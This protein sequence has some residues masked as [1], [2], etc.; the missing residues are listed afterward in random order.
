MTSWI[1][2]VLDQ[3]ANGVW[4][5]KDRKDFRYSDGDT[6]EN[7]LAKA[8]VRSKDLSSSSVELEKWIRDWP[9]EYHLSSSR[10]RLLRHFTYDKSKSVL[11]VGC[12][13]GAITRFL[14]ETFRK[15]VA[16]EGSLRRAEIARLRC[17]DLANVEIVCAPFQELVYRKPF[18][19]AFCIGVFE[20]SRSF[21]TSADP[22][23]AVLRRMRE[24]LTPEGTLVLAIENQFGLKYFASAEED[25]TNVV[26]DGIEGYPRY[27]S[28]AR[29]FGYH[30]LKERLQRHFATVEFYFPYPDYKIPRCILSSA[31]FT[32]ASMGELVGAVSTPHQWLPVKPL[33]DEKLAALEIARN[34]QLPFFS[35]SFLV[36]ARNGTPTSV[37]FDQLGVFYSE[38]RVEPL[39]C[40]STIVLNS[41]STVSVKKT[42]L[43]GVPSVQA[44]RLTLRSCIDEWTD[45]LSLHSQLT[46][47]SREYGR[48]LEELFEPGKVWL[49]KL[50]SLTLPGDANRVDGKYLDALWKNAYL[51]GSDCRFIDQEWEWQESIPVNVLV[52]RAIYQYLLSIDDIVDA[53]PVLKRGRVRSLIKRIAISI[54]ANPTS[55]DFEDF[56]AMESEIASTVLGGNRSRYGLWLTAYLDH[57]GVLAAWRSIKGARKNMFKVARRVARKGRSLVGGR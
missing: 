11:E 5:L 25:H 57:R 1:A 8:I 47:R 23:D 7:Y 39:R 21:V 30:E 17:R 2:N 31:A 29:T 42:P 22:Y 3:A 56:I 18:D 55:A 26:F 46:K 51:Q 48:S 6:A 45:G 32:H 38:E 27:A 50:R 53:L 4:V 33:F 49:D 15:V 37:S 40:V 52:I 41:N 36:L 20:Y 35:N 44:G 9:S 12:G 28:G 16:V 19:L 54:G 10:A 24:L 43:S 34:H 14:G 13:C